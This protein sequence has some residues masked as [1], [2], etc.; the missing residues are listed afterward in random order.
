MN[1][2]PARPV[3]AIAFFPF[4][5]VVSCTIGLLMFVLAAVTVLSFWGAEQVIFDIPQ[6]P[7]GRPGGGR[8]Y[9]E[10]R[11]EG[12]IVYPGEERVRS[13][14]LAHPSR[15]GRTAYGRA[16]NDLAAGRA[17]SLYFFVRPKGIQA[18]RRALAYAYAAG[19]GTADA[20]A[21]G[22][23][24]FPIGCQ[25]LF[26]PGPIRVVHAKPHSAP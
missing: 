2:H 12:I 11:R 7:G 17:R 19:G 16:L 5:S 4:L 13:E 9:V 10:C 21:R 26:M 15:W 1:R 20:A 8:I 23:A 18:F 6:Q 24:R 25:I 14:A 22:A 3:G